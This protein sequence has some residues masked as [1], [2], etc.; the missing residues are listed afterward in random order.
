MK[1][2]VEHEESVQPLSVSLH[3]PLPSPPDTARYAASV[4]LRFPIIRH[5]AVHAPSL[6]LALFSH[7]H[8]T[9]IH[10]IFLKLGFHSSIYVQNAL[11]NSYGTSGT[12]SLHIFLKLFH[13][14]SHPDLVSWS[15]LISSFAKHGFLNKALTLFQQMQLRHTDILPDGVIMLCVLSAVSSLGALELGIWLHAFISRTKLNLTVPLGTALIN[16]YYRCGDID[17]SVKGV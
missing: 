6:A 16:I 9:N 7:M 4:L 2:L 5:L 13:E 1:I 8:R 17:R 3:S 10:S 15:S 11:L 12:G 14:I